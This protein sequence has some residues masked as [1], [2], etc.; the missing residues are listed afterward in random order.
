LPTK[1][2]IF[3]PL[4]FNSANFPSTRINPL[5]TTFVYSNQ[6]SNKSP[7]KK[8]ASASFF[9]VS[10]QFTNSFSLGLLFSEVGAPKCW[11]D[12]KYIFFW[13]IQV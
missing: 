10:S 12:A 3:I 11:S 4:S 9:I 6:K 8:I 1:K 13:S 5:G 2:W 7:N